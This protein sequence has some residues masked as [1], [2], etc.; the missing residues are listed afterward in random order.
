MSIVEL[1]MFVVAI[2]NVALLAAVIVLAVR[3]TSL[4]SAAE[5]LLRDEGVP[6]MHKMNRIAEDVGRV[7]GGMRELGGRFTGTAARVMDQVEPPI[8]QLTALVAGIRVG[9]G[10]V[11]DPGHH[12]NGERP[13]RATGESFRTGERIMR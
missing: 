7:S 10:R 11:F 12:G 2:V 6:L 9:L 5:R 4:L 13:R 1:S 3:L 8:R